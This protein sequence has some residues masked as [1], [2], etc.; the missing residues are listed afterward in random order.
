[1]N[2]SARERLAA[3]EGAVQALLSRVAE[4]EASRAEA[5]ARRDEVE[6][7]LREMSEGDADQAEMAKRLEALE[8]ENEELRHRIDEGLAG[9]DRLLARIRF[10][11]NQ[12]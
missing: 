11:E 12:R 10:L 3:L 8:A 4:A 6:G 7:L 9:V 1:V 2:S 5:Q